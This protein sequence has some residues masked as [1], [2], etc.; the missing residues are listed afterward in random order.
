MKPIQDCVDNVRWAEAVAVVRLHPDAPTMHGSGA[1]TLHDAFDDEALSELSLSWRMDWTLCLFGGERVDERLRES[2]IA[3]AALP[4]EN[5]PAH[6]RVRIRTRLLGRWVD[7]SPWEA[8]P[9]PRLTRR[10]GRL[11][12]G[13]WTPPE[14]EVATQKA[15]TLDGWIEDGSSATLA[16]RVTQLNHL[17]T[18][19]ANELRL[20]GT[21]PRP[22]A[23]V[24]RS[25]AIFARLFAGGLF[26][27]GFAGSTLAILAA[28]GALVTGAK[29]WEARQSGS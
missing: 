24:G 25:F 4:L 12:L 9:A 22:R 13:W 6:Y 28:Y 14:D 1:A 15:A 19:W 20:R 10:R 29:V 5:S 16:D 8:S 11:P 21:A 17:S 27:S 18:L 7:G 26:S 23:F 3:A 2:L